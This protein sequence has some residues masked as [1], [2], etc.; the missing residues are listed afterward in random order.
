MPTRSASVA[1]AFDTVQWRPPQGYSLPVEV[2]RVS[3][4]Y[5]RGTPAH[6]RGPQRVE[7]FMLMGVI[8]GPARHTIDFAPLVLDAGHW[9]LLRPG[10]MQR[11]DFARMWDGWILVFKADFLPPAER[12]QMQ[13]LQRLLGQ[14]ED[15]PSV[16]RLSADAHRACSAAVERMSIDAGAPASGVSDLLLYQLCALLA[17]LRLGSGDA[18]ERGGGPELSRVTRLRQLI[19]EHFRVRHAVRWY[20]DRIGCAGKTL[21]RATQEMLGTT[22]KALLAERIA[23]EAKRL[24]CYSREPVQNIALALGL[25]EPSNFVKF[26]KRLAGCTP[27]AF[28][29]AQRG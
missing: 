10:Q 26:F 15:L 9:M 18:V 1:D 21:N 11:F 14:V 24:L 8:R 5:R 2:M 20:A 7:F 17:R 4:L 29:A 27:K 28:R 23:L 19:D 25:D 16:I 6:F 13:P 22:V 12:R 3:D